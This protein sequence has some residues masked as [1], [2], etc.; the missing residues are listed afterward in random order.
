MLSGGGARA[1]YQVGVLQA[2]VTLRRE[3]LGEGAPNPFGIL[4]GTSAGA[5]NAAALAC[6]ADSF[7][8]G[9]EAIAAVWRNF[10]AGQVYRTDALGIARSGAQWLSA[11]SV[12][13]MLARWRKEGPHSLLD[14]GPLAEL[15]R[16][17]APLELL[18]HML[19]Q[20]H[21][22]ALAIGASSYTGGEHFTFFESTGDM[23]GYERS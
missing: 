9:V 19:A 6:R 23:T 17:W 13:W 14:N 8:A 4:C 16:H 18:P 20:R 12:G 3:Y 21:L 22:R 5:I 11:I 2:L 1:A 10:N 15:L 7:D